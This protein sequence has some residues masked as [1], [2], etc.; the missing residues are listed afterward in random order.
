M[1]IFDDW[2]DDS[3][4]TFELIDD[5][6]ELEHYGT[7]RHSGRYPYGSGDDPY[8]NST[9]FIAY[10]D[11]LHKQGMAEKDIAKAV[12][13]SMRELRDRKTIAKNQIRREQLRTIEQYK[14]KQWSNT[15]I[16]EK[17]GINESQVRGLLSRSEKI[18]NDKVDMTADVLKE[19]L[20]RNPYLDVGAGTEYHMNV[21]TTQLQAALTK[22]K[23]EGYRVDKIKVKQ[24]GTD[25]ETTIKVLSPPG[26]EFGDISRN[27]YNIGSPAVRATVDELAFKVSKP[28]ISVDPKRVMVRYGEEGGSLADGTI[29]VRRGVDDISLGENHYAQVRVKVGDGHFLK[30]V[31]VYGDNMPDGVD[32]V[33][34]TNKH[35]TG[36]K[37]DAMKPLKDD[38]NMPFGSMTKTPNTYFDSKGKE[39]QSA[40]NIVN[41]EGDWSKWSKTL[42]SQVL[43]KQQTSLAK[44]QLG[45]SLEAKKAELEE[46]RSLDNPTVRKKLLASY[47]DGADAAAVDLKAKKLPRTENSVILP[48]S[49]LKDTEIYAPHFRDGESVALVRHPHGGRFEIPILTVNNR[50]KEA[51]SVITNAAKDA[52]GINHNVAERLSGADFDGDTVLVI[53]NDK[54]FIKNKSPLKGLQDFDPKIYQVDHETITPSYKQKQM[55][56]ASN[57]ITDMTIK[58][59]TDSEIARAVRH[60]MVVIDSEKHHLDY[61]ASEEDNGIKALRAKYQTDPDTGNGGASTL[62]SRAK[63]DYVVPNRKPRSASKGGPIN[64]D[65]G[66]LMYEETG[67]TYTNKD[68]VVVSKKTKSTK[69]AE[70][71]DANELSSGR[72]IEKIYADY[73][74]GMKS[75]AN[76]ARK[77]M[78]NTKGITY[79]PAANKQYAPQVK[80]LKASLDLALQN[81][82]LERQAQL[83]AGSKMKVLKQSNPDMDKA[84][85]KKLRGQV[86]NMARDTVNAR[87]PKVPISAKEWEAI[88]SG[89]IS[90]NMLEQILT[91]ADLDRVKELATPRAKKEISASKVSRIKSMLA[92]GYPASDIADLLGVSTSTIGEVS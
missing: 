11:G 6:D 23:T 17:L 47:A 81:A 3:E 5:G 27:K 57:L 40:L 50:N 33:F 88:Q 8:Q 30:G 46:I 55:G 31:A 90:N 76:S 34:N 77:E 71:R 75:L 91:N 54:G 22:L 35:D 38:P 18:K 72:P 74:N 39:K 1:S 70:A 19:E 69:M 85:E 24:M 14:A 45:I 80:S 59:A 73:A 83:L 49:S 62:I 4:I 84:K 48:I 60:S 25:N 9:S 87:K 66:E 53:P 26:T 58:G 78:I 86:L 65:T 56:I 20:K 29:Q 89:A 28:P 61:K 92:M 68:G 43:S 79:S 82:P 12:G 15:A 7:P 21:S 16:G 32:I 51:K 36:N 37:L 13:V 67:Y 63:S 52:V 2:D 10:V 64:K 44:Q 41:E 42:S